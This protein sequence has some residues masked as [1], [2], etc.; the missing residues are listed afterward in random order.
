M[1][2]I[3]LEVFEL[4]FTSESCYP[5]LT[6][7]AR[8]CQSFLNYRPALY[9]WWREQSSFI[10][11]VMCFPQGLLNF[12]VNIDG[13]AFTVKFAKAFSAQD[14]E[15]PA[16]YAKPIRM[17]TNSGHLI[18]A[19]TNCMQVSCNL[20]W[21]RALPHRCFQIFGI[22]T[23]TMTLLL[24]PRKHTLHPCSVSTLFIP[25]LLQYLDFS[26]RSDDNHEFLT[27]LPNCHPQ[28]ELFVS[29]YQIFFCARPP[30]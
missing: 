19:S 1:T 8:T 12:K 2:E 24:A 25:N 11:L 16:V 20:S 14:W 5:D 22:S 23:T 26:L 28:I 17:M 7:L 9:V 21:S 6:C 3:L 30:S 10:P 4:V 27:H 29:R 18:C 15:R 13:P